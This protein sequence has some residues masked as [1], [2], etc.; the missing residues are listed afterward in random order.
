MKNLNGMSRSERRRRTTKDGEG[1]LRGQGP[2]KEQLE[3]LERGWVDNGDRTVPHSAN[4]WSGLDGQSTVADEQFGSAIWAR[5][6]KDTD[7]RSQM[8]STAD[9]DRLVSMEEDGNWKMNDRFDGRFKKSG[10]K[11]GGSSSRKRSLLGEKQKKTNGF[12]FEGESNELD[13]KGRSRW[14]FH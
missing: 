4:K 9:D 1:G 3:R 5:W 11:G 13:T 8:Q 10:L 12:L 2:A 6:Y 7:E 14:L